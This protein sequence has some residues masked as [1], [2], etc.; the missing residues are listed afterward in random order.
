[1]TDLWRRLAPMHL[2]RSSHVAAWTG[3]RLL[4]WGGQTGPRD[5][6]TVPPNGF[7]HDPFTDRW[8]A[9]PASPLKGRLGAI[10]AWTGTEMLIWGGLPLSPR[11][12]VLMEG[13]AYHP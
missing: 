3:Q 1:V 12:P 10:S 4:M 6:P 7:A 13:A 2:A 8:S 11:E 9:M 5:L